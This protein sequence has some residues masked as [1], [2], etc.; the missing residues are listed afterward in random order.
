MPDKT[1]ENRQQ[2]IPN[3]MFNLQSSRSPANL[4]P[5]D[6][7]WARNADPVLTA[8]DDRVDWLLDQVGTHLQPA[9]NPT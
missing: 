4:H 3:E 2:L 8:R 7:L 9:W 6:Q 1:V 5:C